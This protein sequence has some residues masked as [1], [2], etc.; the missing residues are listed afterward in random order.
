MSGEGWREPETA[1]A[2]GSQCGPRDADPFAPPS[3]APAGTAPTPSDYPGAPG[4]RDEQGSEAAAYGTATAPPYGVPPYGSMPAVPPYGSMPAVPPQP[5]A[6]GSSSY[7]PSAAQPYGYPASGAQPYGY[8]ASGQPAYGYPAYGYPPYGYPP[9]PQRTSGL[10]VASLVLGL[11]WIYWIG[12]ILAVI[13]G[14][15][16]L[17]EIKRDPRVGGRGLAIAG[18]VLGYIGLGVL[19]LVIVAI[20]V[21]P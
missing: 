13:F 6:Y 1:A 7:S 4:Y 16:A 11:V 18:V 14:H 17:A 19:V 21:N 2:T 12:S 10:A 20:A 9:A 8:P 5:Q 15:I 3:E